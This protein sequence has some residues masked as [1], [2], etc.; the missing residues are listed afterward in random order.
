[1]PPLLDSITRICPIAR[2]T[3]IGWAG[4]NSASQG[5]RPSLKA[6]LREA[7]IWTILRRIAR[8]HRTYCD[9]VVQRWTCNTSA[10]ETC[11]LVHAVARQIEERAPVLDS[12]G[13]R[14]RRNRGES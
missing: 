12:L 6:P 5:S 2:S 8:T 3:C 7:L 4:C 14:E 9:S 10:F 13:A 1:M 11:S